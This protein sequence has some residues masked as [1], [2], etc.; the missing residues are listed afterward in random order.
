MS[1]DSKPK[2]RSARATALWYVG[3]GGAEL[4]DEDV[5]SAKEGEVQVRALFGALSRGTERLVYS[6]RI[7]ASEHQRMRSPHM[8]G[9]FPFPVKY[10]YSVV[11]L[12]ETGPRELCG[13]VVFAPP[14]SNS[15]DH[16]RQRGGPAARELD[17]CACCTRC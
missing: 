1:P 13:R 6:G 5:P 14:S 15:F 17:A 8:G 9:A 4:R 3:S 11:G 10:G 12:I 7:P 2:N 16:S